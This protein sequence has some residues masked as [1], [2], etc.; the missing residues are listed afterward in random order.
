[1]VKRKKPRR[2]RR[3]PFYTPPSAR[4]G[5]GRELTW[6]EAKRIYGFDTRKRKRRKR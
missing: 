3:D 1:M 6:A 2:K 5:H 4:S